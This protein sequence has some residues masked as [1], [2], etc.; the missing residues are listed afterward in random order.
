M[1]DEG[2]EFVDKAQLSPGSSSRVKLLT[3]GSQV[4][5]YNGEPKKSP[6]NWA[7]QRLAAKAERRLNV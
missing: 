5:S 1:N 7:T 2:R 3:G 6:R 4:E